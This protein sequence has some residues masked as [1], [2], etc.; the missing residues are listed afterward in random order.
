MKIITKIIKFLYLILFFVTPLIFTFFNSELFELPKMFFVYLVTILIVTLHFINWL[1]GNVHLFQKN[2]FNFPLLLFLISQIICT[3]TSI[4]IQ[5]SFYGYSSRLNGGLLSILSFSFLYWSLLPY[6]DDK[7]KKD[8]INFSLF[9]GALVAIYGVSQHFGIDK[10]M[11]V[12]DVQSRVFSTLGQPNWLAAYVCILIPFSIHKYLKSL[13]KFSA[14]SYLLLTISYYL[15]LLFTKSKSGIIAGI[16]SISIFF[17]VYFVQEIKN[18][19]LRGFVLII[20]FILL[21]FTI[22]NP[23]K[24]YIFPQKNIS[25]TSSTSSSTLNITPS[26]DIRKIV[27]KGSFDLFKKF[28]LV[29]TGVE[30]FAYSYY[31]TRPVE[32]NLTSEWDFLYNK[33]HNEYLNY[34]AT[35]GLVGTIPYLF[36]IFSVLFFLIKNLIRNSTLDIRNLPVR[37][38]GLSLVILSSYLSILITNT[39]GFSVVTV[40]LFFFLL[41]A[42][43]P[44]ETK[45]INSNKSP[46]IIKNIVIGI[47]ILISFSL[48]QNIFSSYFADILFAKSEASDGRQDYQL[49]YSQISQS[50]SLSPN[51][52]N[53]LITYANTAAKM[54]ILTKDQKYIDQAIK[55]ADQAIAISPANI[56]FW[57]QRAQV[58]YYLSSL[59]TKYFV[60]TA[61]SMLQAAKLAPTDAKIYFSL[62]QFLES[63]S[64][65]DDAATYYQKAIDLKSNYDHAYF[66]LAQIYY[67]QKKYD[68]AKKNLELNLQYAPTNTDAQKMLEEITKIQDVKI[69]K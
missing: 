36:L 33:A 61:E 31:W 15:A 39:A 8:I 1:R 20:I 4:D 46:S 62:G 54:A 13:N 25:D 27:W 22:N 45:P 57:K 19:K 52:P 6:L 29:G 59:D 68:L 32:H 24:D 12:Q 2:F 47:V 49:A 42:L 34:L 9:S 18:K 65:F 16:I 7:F 10:N 44:S 35:T 5:T 3:F 63:A 11:W 58:Y 67:N 38:A 53:Y 43:I 55:S 50:I 69:K 37:Q 66:A 41:P 23:I 14:T 48:L 21:S 51:N 30:T 40:S 56:N 60:T 17:L 64:L 26:G 28:P